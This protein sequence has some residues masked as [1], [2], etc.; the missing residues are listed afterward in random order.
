M[1]APIAALAAAAAAKTLG[2]AFGGL[3]NYNDIN[4][5]MEAYDNRANQGISTLEQGKAGADTAFNP[6]T[7]VGA[8]GA[9]GFGSS[10]ANRQMATQPT[11]SNFS[12]QGVG[13]FLD[14]SAAYTSDQAAKATQ[15]SAIAKGGMGGGL[16]KALS[17]N[18]NQMA[19]T[20]YNNAFGQMMDAG[21]ANF[22]QGQQLYTNK[23]NFDQSQIDNYGNLA[24]LGLNATQ[25]NQNLQGQYNMGINKNFMD[26]ADQ[27]ASGWNAK[28]KV[29]N[30]TLTGL[31]NNLVGGISSLFGGK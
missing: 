20:N 30:D 25:A 14:P 8:Q 11:A 16:A 27:R 12:A 21:N 29:F 22:A 31:G 19:M 28:G 9:A 4:K 6:Y 10:I 15:A 7:S 24:G 18:A 17:N 1:P 26:M 5:G 13:A 3:G 2:G 23:T